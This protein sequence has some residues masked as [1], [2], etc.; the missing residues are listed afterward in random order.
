MAYGRIVVQGDRIEH[1]LNGK[2]VVAVTLGSPEMESAWDACER[3]DIKRLRALPK[4][5]SPIAITHHGTSVW[6]RNLRITAG[7]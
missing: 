5:E 3:Q 6:Y 2:R 7:K 4:R 1:Y